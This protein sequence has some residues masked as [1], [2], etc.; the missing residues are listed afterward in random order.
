MQIGIIG[1]GKIGG[2]TARLFVDAGHEVAIANSRGPDSLTG[3]A[4]EL[5]DRVRAAT[6][7]DAAGFGDVVLVAIPFGRYRELP[8]EPFGETI[9][10]DATNYFPQRDGNFPEL[11]E[12]RTTSSELVAAHL[13][14]ARV[15]KA[16]NSMQWAVLRD[17]GAPDAGDDRLAL[18]VAGDDEDAKQPVSALIEE[19]GFAP[20]DTG[21]LAEGGRRQQTG[22]PVFTRLI[23]ARDAEEALAASG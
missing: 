16:F 2:T 10:V 19:I 9:V 23:A 22:S 3:L 7:E 8:P 15:V 6:V 11:D 1:S 4:E 13:S 17:R 12:D 21:S 20:I 5:G 14:D 18:F